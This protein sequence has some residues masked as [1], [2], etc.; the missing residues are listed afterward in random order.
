MTDIITT[1]ERVLIVYLSTRS[2]MNQL[3]VSS[4]VKRHSLISLC[5]WIFLIAV[6]VKRH[7]ITEK[8]M[9]RTQ[10][11]ERLCSGSSLLLSLLCCVAWI[12]VEL[13]IQEHNR[14]ISHSAKFCDKIETEIIRKVQKNYARWQFENTRRGEDGKFCYV[15]RHLFS[16]SSRLHRC[17]TRI[18]V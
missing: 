11:L 4:K 7:G 6:T 5:L 2:S 10:M 1:T 3:I 13:R 14:L 12:N 15:S 17:S 18:F 9:N 8:Q 16:C